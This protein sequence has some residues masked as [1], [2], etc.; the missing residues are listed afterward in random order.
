[1]KNIMNRILMKKLINTIIVVVFSLSLFNC[2]GKKQTIENG[3]TR[4]P[5]IIYILADDLGYGDLSVTGQK[6]FS[7]PNI[8]KLAKDGMLFTQHY[9]GSTVCAPSRSSL[10]TGM[11]TGHTF[12]R[13]N[14][15]VEPEGQ[16]PMASSVVTVAEL[17]KSEGYITG[18]FGKWGLGYPSSEGDP[19]NQGF[20]EFYGYNCQRMGHNY[21][22]YHLWHNQTKEILKGNVGTKTETYAPDIIHEKSMAF[23]EK[24]KDTT[25]FMYY[26]SIIPHAELAAPEKYMAKFRGKLLPD[27]EY[28]GEDDGEEY[29]NGGY[30]SQKE[31]HTAFAAMVSLLDQQVGEIRKKVEELGIADNTIIIF[32]SDNGP[33]QEGG[34]DPNYFNSNSDLRGYK[35]D[36]YEGGIRVPMITYWPRKIKP[37]T[38]SNHI[39]A[40]WDFLPTVCEIAQLKT[41]GNIDG[42]SYLPEL[43]GEKQ[44]SHDYLYWEFLEQGGKQAVR[45]GDWKGIRLDMNNNA[46]ASIELYNLASDIGEEHNVAEENSEIVKKIDSIISKEHTYSKEYSFAYEKDSE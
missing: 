38:T 31:P 35:R 2:N 42:I 45:F 28:K 14:R 4:K 30:G 18:A 36:L 6:K 43:L 13:G 16:Y 34:A 39:S 5:N 44:K 17:L 10:M 20:D 1:M 24:N 9:S 3:Q 12:V 25:F 46:K 8:D 40:F 26:P 41:P 27:N 37:N 19:N 15:E 29:K 22:P 7:T 11:H 23:L 21:Y 32:T 33:H